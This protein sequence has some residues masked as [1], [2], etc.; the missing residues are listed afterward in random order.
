MFNHGRWDVSLCNA[1]DALVIFDEIHCYEF[2]TLG[3]IFKT[4]EMLKDYVHF[5]FMSATFPRFLRKELKR[6]LGDRNHK[7]IS[8]S[9]SLDK[10]LFEKKTVEIHKGKKNDYID[11]AIDRIIERY[12]R[13]QKVLVICNT[14]GK[15]KE[16]YEKIKGHG[17]KNVLL[18]N[19]EYIVRDRYY[20]EERLESASKPASGSSFIAVTTQV[21]EV[22]LD[23]D[24][25]VL[26]TEIAPIDAIVQRIGR[27]NR[28]GVKGICDVFVFNYD[29]DEIEK[30]G[31]WSYPY[32]QEVLDKSWSLL[33]EGVL[34]YKEYKDLVDQL[35][36]DD[37][38]DN[39]SI[40]E[41]MNRIEEILDKLDWIYRL[42]LSDQEIEA[43]TRKSDILYVDVIPHCFKNL[44]SKDMDP[45]Q[46]L[47]KIAYWKVKDRISPY[48]GW[49]IADIKYDSE[50]GVI[51]G[52]E[53]VKK[54]VIPDSNVI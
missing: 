33:K 53:R 41:G 12:D 20:K 45:T 46:F 42:N 26:F 35:Y 54:F 6:I 34:A 19:S 25:D 8:V 16:I 3:L 14:I 48:K 15:S 50:Y 17:S 47:L 38:I 22:S 13:G 51:D 24:F 40:Q 39:T 28:R 7:E 18:Y 52:N 43:Q 9:D 10:T 27:V 5:C 49:L 30:S 44:L 23:L 1:R 36:T 31:R 11:H 37:E 29:K 32:P 2:Y 21:V 4:V